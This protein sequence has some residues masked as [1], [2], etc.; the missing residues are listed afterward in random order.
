MASH[1]YVWCALVFDSKHLGVWADS[2]IDAGY[3]ARIGVTGF[4]RLIIR[5][6][7]AS[8]PTREV[9]EDCAGWDF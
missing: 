8:V 4:S 5:D 1:F 6:G 7:T 2:R 3:I 9:F